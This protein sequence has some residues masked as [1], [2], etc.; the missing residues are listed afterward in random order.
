VAEFFD[1]I[2]DRRDMHL[3]TS[4]IGMPPLGEEN[5]R[6][7]TKKTPHAGDSEIHTLEKKARFF[8]SQKLCRPGRNCE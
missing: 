3:W 5:P 7:T 2:F 8:N 6:V 4:R 1:R